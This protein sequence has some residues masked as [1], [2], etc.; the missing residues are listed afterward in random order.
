MTLVGV[1][2]FEPTPPSSFALRTA[3]DREHEYATP[4]E[5]RLEP[6]RRASGRDA[7]AYSGL[8]MVSSPSRNRSSNLCLMMNNTERLKA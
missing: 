1:T 8:R 6:N 7:S 3:S 4:P 5:P 2:G